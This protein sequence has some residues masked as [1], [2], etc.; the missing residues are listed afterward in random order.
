MDGFRARSANQ[1]E[2]FGIAE[3]YADDVGYMLQILYYFLV[4]VPTLHQT[5]SSTH[6]AF[7]SRFHV[8]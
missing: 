6:R 4:L 5:L 2:F 8:Y 1:Q 7:V 3:G